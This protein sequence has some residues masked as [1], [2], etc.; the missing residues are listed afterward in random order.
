MLATLIS[1]IV[2][3]VVLV[4]LGLYQPGKSVFE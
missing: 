2:S 1:G 3:V 4:L